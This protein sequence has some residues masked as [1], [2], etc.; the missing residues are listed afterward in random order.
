M[1]NTSVYT[2]GDYDIHPTSYGWVITEGGNYI[3]DDVY[4]CAEDAIEAL[5]NMLGELDTE[6]EK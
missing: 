5:N 4:D 1:K 6:G 2:D 3:D